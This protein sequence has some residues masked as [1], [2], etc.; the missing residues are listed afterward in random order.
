M[1]KFYNLKKF[2]LRK[3]LELL[4]WKK[5]PK[6]AFIKKNLFFRWLVDGKLN[7]FE[8]CIVNTNPNKTGII[9]V[10]ENETINKYSY[11]EIYK[12]VLILS[13]FLIK[14]KNKNTKVLIHSSASIESAISM[15]A[16]ANLG[17]HFCVLFKELELEAINSRVKIFKPDII[18]SNGSPL[19]FKKVKSV[20]KLKIFNLKNI[21]N[22]KNKR[23]FIK[24]YKI[25]HYKADN[26][27][28]TL[29]TSGSTGDPK[30][31][32]HAT[33]GYLLYAKYTCI[34]QFGMNQNSVVVTASDAGWI[35]GHTY[36]LFGPLSLGATTILI[37]KP[38]SLLNQS[39]LK[40]VLKMKVTIFYLP[41]TLIRLMRQIY[42]DKIFK[43]YSIKTLGSMGEPLAKSVGT[44]FSNAFNLK[45]KAII[46]TYYQTETSGIICSPKYKD[47]STV[48]PHG[49]V[50]RPVSKVIKISNLDSQ[51]KE[52]KIHSP[53][54]GCM[55]NVINGYS[56]YKKYWDKNHRFRMFDFATK[57]KSYIE[58]HGR[59]DDVIN[60]R[61]HRI[62]S[63]EIESILLKNKT[64]V[65][66]CAVAIPNSLEGSSLILFLVT[67]N[68]QSIDVEVKNRIN[69]NF[70][71]FALPK[72][73]IYLSGLPKTRSGKIL[74][75]LL[76]DI[77]LK[78]NDNNYGD[79]STIIN[80]HIV[81]E[82]KKKINKN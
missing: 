42:K 18:L 61:G 28:F 46:N 11:Q 26:D 78:P 47:N 9:T 50:G 65:E 16:C 62:G 71:S 13:N 36:A 1:K 31:I 30:G 17:M 24:Y 63:E 12:L 73:I 14:L 57:T 20:K 67:A 79:I 60:I 5:K 55:K 2:W 29:F 21:L 37:E 34:E 48:S 70:G 75:R 33:G 80:S 66:A 3:S 72:K 39:V 58:I 53:W 74:R 52:I 59:T 69:A 40:K 22:K 7:V 56:Y 68:N 44:W 27:L 8:N 38:I 19:I 45:K 10:S 54:P 35:N 4:Y 81:K 82:I 6:I 77:L 76:R 41:V 49:S 32:T 15:L 25:D 51:K 43:N 23:K 64:I